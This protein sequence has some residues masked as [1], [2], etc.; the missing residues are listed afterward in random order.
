[1][2]TT[3]QMKIENTRKSLGYGH[4]TNGTKVVMFGTQE[5]GK[6]FERYFDSVEKAE[7]HASK[8]GWETT[9]KTQEAN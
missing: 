5:N 6:W 9:N 7:K 4:Y 2:K 1:M 8:K 3:V